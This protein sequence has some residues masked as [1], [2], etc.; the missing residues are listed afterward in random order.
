M[1][2]GVLVT[3]QDVLQ[4]LGQWTNT[5]TD[6]QLANTTMTAAL[7]GFSTGSLVL[8]AYCDN[9]GLASVNCAATGGDATTEFT[10]SDVNFASSTARAVQFYATSDAS[11]TYVVQRTSSS[12]GVYCALSVVGIPD[13]VEEGAALSSGTPSGTIGTQRRATLGATSTQSTGTF[14]GVVSATQGDITGITAAQVFAGQYSGGG[15]ATFAAN[16]TVSDSTPDVLITGLNPATT[17]YYAVMHR[18]GTNN[19]TPLTGSF[20]TAV[21]TSTATLSLVDSGGA[22]LNAQ[23][24]NFW[25]RTTLNG[26]AVDGGGVGLSVTSNGSGVFSFS[27]LSVDA[28]A[29]FITVQNPLDNTFSANYPVT[30]VAGV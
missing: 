3:A 12:A 7:S 11:P 10:S 28:G 2:Q 8:G 6:G 20:T 26:A 16:N 22:A 4:N 9:T 30:F 19:S 13:Y 21:A 18:V 25:T 24:L 17:Y 29:G 1:A 14:Y 23:T 27:G 15:A 5:A